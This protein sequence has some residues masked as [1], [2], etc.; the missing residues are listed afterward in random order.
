MKKT[1]LLV[2]FSLLISNECIADTFAN[3]KNPNGIYVV[4]QKAIF[5]LQSNGK[6][7]DGTYNVLWYLVAFN[8][9]ASQ[10]AKLILGGEW[11]PSYQQFLLMT[12]ID[13]KSEP[14]CSGWDKKSKSWSLAVIVDNNISV[15][16]GKTCSG[17]R[18]SRKNTPSNRTPTDKVCVRYETNMFC[19][20][21]CAKWARRPLVNT[22]LLKNKR[23]ALKLYSYLNR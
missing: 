9:R 8:N 4:N 13:F 23:D 17:Y 20:K 2:I 1:I 12:Y 22:Y 15:G 11:Y 6:N 10:P 7:S 19:T 21:F 16:N 5:Q 14:A 3:I 18:F